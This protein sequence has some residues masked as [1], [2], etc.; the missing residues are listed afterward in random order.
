MPNHAYYFEHEVP[1]LAYER[2]ANAGPGRA[3]I[4]LK[5]VEGV[6]AWKEVALEKSPVTIPFRDL[7]QPADSP[8]LVVFP[9][10]TTV[11]PPPAEKKEKEPEPP[12]LRDEKK[13]SGSFSLDF[14]KDTLTV[15]WSSQ[16][17]A[18]AG[19]G[20]AAGVGASTAPTGDWKFHWAAPK[21]SLDLL[22]DEQSVALFL[23]FV[24]RFLYHS[25]DAWNF[26][27][28]W[29]SKQGHGEGDGGAQDLQTVGGFYGWLA[30]FSAFAC[31]YAL[32][33]LVHDQAQ[34]VADLLQKLG[35]ELE[36]DVIAS[37][38][39]EVVVGVEADATMAATS[40]AR[41]SCLKNKRRARSA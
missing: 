33:D 37:W 31:K 26:A 8:L 35:F 9:E 5:G 2:A 3:K 34:Y 4:Y 41:K 40:R 27:N 29:Y 10:D 18:G 1:E 19:V 13:F 14:G 20:N 32:D 39:G 36:L 21:F 25:C 15:S 28:H 6:T 11:E 24:L 38:E 30:L 7:V 16:T 22:K 23:R 12:T 17:G